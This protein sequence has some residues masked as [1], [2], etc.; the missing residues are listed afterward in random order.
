MSIIFDNVDKRDVRLQSIDDKA[1]RKKWYLKRFCLG[2]NYRI[3]P[4]VP[5]LS[6]VPFAAVQH[7]RAPRTLIKRPSFIPRPGSFPSLSPGV[8]PFLP[9]L[10]PSYFSF[11]PGLTQAKSS[12]PTLFPAPS[13][14]LSLARQSFPSPPRL[15]LSSSATR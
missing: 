8:S 9:H 14:A 13:P 11:P 4:T 15:I 12:L 3:N 5:S 7:E 10:L 1:K 2:V 6:P